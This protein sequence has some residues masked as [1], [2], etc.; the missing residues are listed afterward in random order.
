MT[1]RAR[2][3]ELFEM[4]EQAGSDAQKP[5]A[6]VVRRSSGGGV[7][8]VEVAAELIEMARETLLPRYPSLAPS[9]LSRDRASRAAT[10]SC[11]RRAPAHSAYVRALPGAPRRARAS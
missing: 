1:L 10:G 2:V 11:P 3:V 8:G 9:H 7:T 5:A 4:A 6:A